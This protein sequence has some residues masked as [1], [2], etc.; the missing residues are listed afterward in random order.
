MRFQLLAASSLALALGAQA[1]NIPAEIGELVRRASTTSASSAKSTAASS[2]SSSTSSTL[3]ADPQCTNGPT[4][5]SCWSNGFSIAT[6]FDQKHPNTGKTV[7]YNLEITNTTCNPD[8][9]GDRVC[10]LINGQYPGPTIT[11]NWGDTLSVTVKNSLQNNGTGIHWHGIRQY[12][13]NEMDGVNGVTE[14]PL[15]PGDTK[16]Y[17]FLC[18]QFGT[19]WYHSHYSAQ[20]GDGVVGPI[21]INGPAS[22][23]YDIDLGPFPVTDWYYP[24]S[25]QEN[26]NSEIALQQGAPGPPADNI[27]INGTNKNAKNTTGS[28]SVTKITAGKKYRLRLIN[29]AVDN[30][31]RVSLDNHLLQVMTTDFVPVK[32]TY[33]Q[34][35]LLGIGQRYD[36]VINANQT[37]GNYWFR[38]TAAADCQS[39]NS[40]ANGALAIFSYDSVSTANP[41][42]SAWPTPST[43]CFEPTNL[44]PFW[45]QPVPSTSAFSN[46]DVGLTTGSVTI[47][48]NLT[49]WGINATSIDVNWD[50]PVR[51]YLAEGNTSYPKGENIIQLP[52]ENVWTYWLLQEVTNAPL[53]THP[54]HL[55]GHDFFVL[56]S[57]GDNASPNPTTAPNIVFNPATDAAKLNWA[58]P[59][60]RDTALLPQGGWLALA[61]YTN[62]PGPWLMHCHIAWH[63][64]EGLGLDFLEAAS[65]VP[66]PSA[67][68]NTTCNNWNTYQQNAIY[69]QDDSGL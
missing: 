27:L 16:T 53:I 44:A 34:T 37:A 36:V 6:D 31:I 54:I 28:Y 58:T 51:S 32:P 3:S 45:N 49:V 9:N 55:H 64:S 19:S 43:G 25:W 20:Y 4:T 18:T 10:M 62:N 1:A 42:S 11:A 29:T 61:F 14:C 2:T 7:T 56:G 48:P 5:R 41:S 39:G 65:Q 66:A 15:A 63:I 40:N 47:G 21:V 33:N 8:G 38:A 30:Q 57:S 67:Q 24:T 13:T 23:N 60:R 17:T 69:K 46:L 68:F 50:K 12:L 26:D 52:N 22:A 59:I 35:I